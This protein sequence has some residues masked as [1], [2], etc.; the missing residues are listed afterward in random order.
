[1]RNLWNWFWKPS[2]TYAWGGIFLFG[3][4][5]GVIGWG[6]FNT[7][8]EATNTLDFCV[9]CHEMGDNVGSEYRETIHFQKPHRG[10]RELFRL[11]RPRSL[12]LQG[13]AQDQG[14]QRTVPLGPGAPSIR[15]RNSKTSA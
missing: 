5:A 13:R 4:F 9:A 1:M 10:S 3:C 7:V 11:P 15:P 12:G 2:R 8:M 14:N 6:G